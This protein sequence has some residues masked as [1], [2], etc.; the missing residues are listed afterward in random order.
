MQF[1][2]DWG[3]RKVDKIYCMGNPSWEAIKD[4][5]CLLFLGICVSDFAFSF[6]RK[7]KHSERRSMVPESQQYRVTKPC[8]TERLYEVIKQNSTVLFV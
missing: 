3:R 1:G 7:R 4:R 2:W 6:V 5:L 8:H